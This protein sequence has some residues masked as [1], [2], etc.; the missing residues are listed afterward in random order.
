MQAIEFNAQLKNGVIELPAVYQHWQ[1]GQA[2]K[3]IVL[4]ADSPTESTSPTPKNLNHHAGR[5]G[6][7]QDPMAF[8]NAIREEWA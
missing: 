3:V 8:Q 7:T 1:E 2:V 6:L 5:I 4:A